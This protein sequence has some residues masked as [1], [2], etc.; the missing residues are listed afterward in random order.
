[1]L[2]IPPANYHLLADKQEVYQKAY[3]LTKNIEE[4]SGEKIRRC[5][6]Q[7]GEKRGQDRHSVLSLQRVQSS[8][9]S[10]WFGVVLLLTHNS[11]LQAKR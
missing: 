1:M 2:Y 7:A 6:Q 10:I 9:A 8:V 3:I 4:F 11:L 5:G